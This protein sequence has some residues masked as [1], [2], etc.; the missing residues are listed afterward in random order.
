MCDGVS[1]GHEYQ[2]AIV[3]LE[4]QFELCWVSHRNT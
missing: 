1:A 3:R 2:Q 4:R